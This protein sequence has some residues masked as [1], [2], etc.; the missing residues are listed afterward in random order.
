MSF[1]DL[2][3]DQLAKEFHQRLNRQAD[4]AAEKTTDYS[5]KLE[6]ATGADLFKYF[7]LINVAAIEKY[8]TQTRIQA[9]LSFRLSKRVAIWAFVLIAG[10]VVLAIY[11]AFF[12]E[13]GLTPAIIATCAGVFTQMISGVFF[14]LY[15]RTLQQFNLFGDKIT[16]AQRLAMSLLVNG[17]IADA[18]KRDD[19]SA[20][21]AT[22][23]LHAGVAPA[24][25]SPQPQPSPGAPGGA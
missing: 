24:P 17:S 7:L 13:G 3:R 12:K 15:N 8:I 9:E 21:L 1:A 5:Q 18:A 6:A 10:G 19:S 14:Y 25:P 22:A 2:F 16:A 11:S 20:D 23:L 4:E